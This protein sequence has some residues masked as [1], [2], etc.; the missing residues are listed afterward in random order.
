MFSSTLLDQNAK[1]K[2][3]MI[4]SETH[5]LI[6]TSVPQHRKNFVKRKLNRHVRTIDEDL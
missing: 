5:M 2:S 3:S 1:I 6:T 4:I